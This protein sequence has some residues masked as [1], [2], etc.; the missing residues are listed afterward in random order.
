MRSFV[1]IPMPEAVAAALAPV[2]AALPLGRRVEPENLHLTMA[3]LG[4]QPD[5]ML[6]EVH[7]ALETIRHPTF[8]LTLSG[9]D[10]FGAESPQLLNIGVQ[11]APGLTEL[12]RRI[13]SRLH[14]LGLQGERRRF[15]PHVTLARFPKIVTRDE[16]GR[17]G[18]FLAGRADHRLPPFRVTEFCLFESILTSDGAHY[19]VLAS[20]PLSSSGTTSTA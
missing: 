19:E 1:A 16:I 11:P 17:L 12:Q 15:H 13:R 10:T 5:Q 7:F 9:L 6:E 2:Q 3:F 8:E 20:Y 14:G 4:D 18:R